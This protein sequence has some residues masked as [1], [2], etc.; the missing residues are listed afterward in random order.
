MPSKIELLAKCKELKL[1][2][3]TGK[4]KEE[5][6]NILEEN[7][8]LFEKKETIQVEEKEG[9]L[10]DPVIHEL[11]QKVK[12]DTR[13]KVCSNCHELGHDKTSDRCLY[14]KEIDNKN[15]EKIKHHILENKCDEEKLAEDMGI[16]FFKYKSLYN[17]IPLDDI[18]QMQEI[19]KE[20]INKTIDN[21][22]YNCELC[23]KVQYNNFVS[24]REWK[25][26]KCICDIC[27][28]SFEEERDKLWKKVI[29]Y[30]K[31]NNCS[32]C[33]IKKIHPNQRFHYDHISMFDKVDTIYCM[34]NRCT[35]ISIIKKELDRC[36][37]VCISCHSLIT[38][39]ENKFIFTKIKCKLIKQLKKN[40]ITEIEYEQEC[41]KYNIL[42]KEKMN[43][44]YDMIRCKQREKPCM[45]NLDIQ[46]DFDDNR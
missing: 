42:Y 21:V 33:N 29:E 44:I 8:I 25:E 34:V 18:L 4:N 45:S 13:R 6:I 12:K 1:K 30:T 39:F 3:C 16:S 46:H 14:N 38:H 27:W 11:C 37:L 35:D 2:S 43:K 41:Q 10:F 19:K 17:E 40:K 7:G 23:N 28:I 5:L 31:I 36:Q 22:T 15:R 20:E 24:G 32:I 26:Y 9:K